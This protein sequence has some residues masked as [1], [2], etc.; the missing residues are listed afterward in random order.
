MYFYL[1]F[2]LPISYMYAIYFYHIHPNT[3][4]PPQKPLFSQPVPLWRV[5]VCV[6]AC[7]CGHVPLTLIMLGYVSIGRGYLPECSNL[8]VVV[9]LKKMALD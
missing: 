3:P 4:W 8:L 1:F 9:P 6:T 2:F 5:C 7:V